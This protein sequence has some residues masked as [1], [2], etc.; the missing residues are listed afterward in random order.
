MVIGNLAQIDT[1][2]SPTIQ[3]YK[4]SMKQILKMYNPYI[5]EKE[6]NNILDFSISK[7]YYEA[8]CVVDNSYT[9]KQKNKTLL[10]MSDYIMKKEPIL[11]AHGTM[12]KKHADC[13][14]PLGVVIQQFLDARGLHKKQM[15]KFP[16]GS[17]DFEKFNLLQSLDKIDAN[18]RV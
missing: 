18:G 11:T 7:R 5:S 3:E 4:K 14:N 16:K 9:K 6:A 1:D 8:T 13:P 10:M 17:E 15:F 12:F 2:T